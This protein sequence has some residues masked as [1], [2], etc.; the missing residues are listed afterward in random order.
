MDMRYTMV[1]SILVPPSR[2]NLSALVD[3]AP[4]ASS[5]ASVDAKY[6]SADLKDYGQVVALLTDV[7][8]RYRGIDAI[9][10]LAAIPAPAKAVS[11]LFPLPSTP[12][13]SLL[14]LKSIARPTT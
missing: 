10:H 4:P 2:S 1:R 13:A 14:I 3:I 11:F 5:E 8:D 6:F 9:I 12:S 7:D